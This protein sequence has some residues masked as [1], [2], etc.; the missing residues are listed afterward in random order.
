[1]LHLFVFVVFGN[2]III[3]IYTLLPLSTYIT[4]IQNKEIKLE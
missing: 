1:M 3:I 4:T 2:V